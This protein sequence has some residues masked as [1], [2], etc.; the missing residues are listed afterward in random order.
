MSMGDSMFLGD[1]FNAELSCAH[2]HPENIPGELCKL[3]GQTVPQH[4]VKGNDGGTERVP[5]G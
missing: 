4:E 5:G 3:C 2:N 1:G